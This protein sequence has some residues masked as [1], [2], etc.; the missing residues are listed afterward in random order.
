MFPALI[1][2]AAIMCVIAGLF[3]FL[4]KSRVCTSTAQTFCYMET[5]FL[6]LLNYLF[7]GFS[8][9]KHSGTCGRSLRLE[10]IVLDLCRFRWFQYITVSFT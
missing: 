2:R 10:H 3:F 6:S 9:M 7:C 8:V 5:P 4:L 1:N